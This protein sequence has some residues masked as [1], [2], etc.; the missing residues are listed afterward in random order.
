M[1][2][3]LGHLHEVR[4]DA[5]RALFHVGPPPVPRVGRGD[6]VLL[7]PL[8]LG[9]DIVRRSWPR[10][11]GAERVHGVHELRGL[12]QALCSNGDNVIGVE[13]VD[14]LAVLR[15]V[16]PEDGLDLGLWFR[17]IWFGGP[18]RPRL[19]EPLVDPFLVGE[20]AIS[21]HPHPGAL[22]GLAS[23]L[24]MDANSLFEQNP[25]RRFVDALQLLLPEEAR[26]RQLER[27]ARRRSA[28]HL[29]HPPEGLTNDL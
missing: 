6:A 1:S 11:D 16:Q 21:H 25:H 9:R 18:V 27:P 2:E 10:P 26:R 24:V 22:S 8:Q 14:E 29:G 23:R 4:E 13:I 15:N 3:R 19:F 20:D 7:E 5:R 12:D 17:F 28:G